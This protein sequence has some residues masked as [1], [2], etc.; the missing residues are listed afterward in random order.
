MEIHERRPPADDR[1]L[2][3]RGLG[4]LDDAREDVLA[5]EGGLRERHEDPE[6]LLRLAAPHGLVGERRR[7][8]E[9]E[10]GRAARLLDAHRELQDVFA[11]RLDRLRLRE[12]L[13]GFLHVAVRECGLGREQEQG[14]RARRR[15]ERALDEEACLLGARGRDEEGT[16]DRRTS[17]LSGAIWSAFS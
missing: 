13:L 1:G 14:D 9:R 7:S 11:G 4:H 5:L 17:T 8:L 3:A 2:V 15:L 12:P 16:N 10:R 6:R